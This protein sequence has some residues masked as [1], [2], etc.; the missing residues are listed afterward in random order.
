MADGMAYEC[1]NC[2]EAVCEF[3]QDYCSES[4]AREVECRA[5][6]SSG[7]AGFTGYVEPAPRQ[8]G[9]VLPTDS[10]ERKQIPIFSG[11]LNYFPLAIAAVARVSKRGN[12]K[13]NPG[14]PLHHSRGKSNDHPDCIAR[15]ILDYQTVN[16]ETGEFDDAAAMAWRALALL[17]E[18]EEKRLGKPISRGS[19]AADGPAPG[20]PVRSRI[21]Y[22]DDYETK[23]GAI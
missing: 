10:E 15:H 21:P 23:S 19:K 22:T 12:D 4:C 17:Q 8:F 13:H 3:D 20:Q 7:F 9:Y 16:P 11:V 2:G 14:Q 1:D 5:N 18:L 6:A